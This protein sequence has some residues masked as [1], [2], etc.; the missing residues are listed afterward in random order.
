MR[1]STRAKKVVAAGALLVG[2]AAAGAAVATT[3]V[4]S[5]ADG[6]QSAA[7]SAEAGQECE[8]RGGPGAGEEALSGATLEKVRAAVLAE[9]PGATVERAET[10]A[11]GTYE[12]HVVTADGERLRVLLDADLSVTG[13]KQ[14][15]PHGPHGGTDGPGG[16][17]G[18]GGPGAPGGAAVPDVAPDEAPSTSPEGAVAG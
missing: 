4:A 14:D 12:A 5:A 15:G 7:T 10:D 11:E 17:A 2:G 9:Y 13:S 18:P 8:G 3:G 16:P 6:T 1:I